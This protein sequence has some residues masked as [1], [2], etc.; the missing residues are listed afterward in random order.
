MARSGINHMNLCAVW[1]RIAKSQQRAKALLSESGSGFQRTGQVIGNGKNI[2]HGWI[3]FGAVV[4]KEQRQTK[5]MNTMINFSAVTFRSLWVV[6]SLLCATRAWSQQA[7]VGRYDAYAGYMYLDS[8]HINLAE[9]GFHMQVG[10]R[11]RWW[12]S[13]GFDYSVATGHTALTPNLLT[14]ALQQQLSTTFRQLAGAG[15]IPPNY[16]LVVPI[17]STTHNFAAGPQFAYRH[18]Q[19]V[20]LFIRPSVGAVHEIATPHATDPIA[21]SVIA[22]LAPSG[23]KQDWTPFYGI[24]GGVDVNFSPHVGVRLQAD[25]VHDHLFN[26]L[27]KDGRNTI[28]LAVGPAFQFGSNVKK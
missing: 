1:D 23:K 28:R 7:Y 21:A 14:N 12:Y 5:S 2:G 8:P 16:A 10:I 27:L 13:L 3:A 11:P 19:P 22:Q 15:L 26:D 6:L 24:G 18:W 17:D 20:T 4:M 25:F 9:R